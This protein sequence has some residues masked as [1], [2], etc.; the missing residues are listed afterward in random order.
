MALGQ[1]VFLPVARL[2]ITNVGGM[3]G[4]GAGLARRS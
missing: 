1:A 4:G 2:R 3:L